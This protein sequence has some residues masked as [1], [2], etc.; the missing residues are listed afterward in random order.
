M[1]RALLALLV[2][3]VL[4]SLAHA[5]A[6][7]VQ[8]SCT[9]YYDPTG[10]L[11]FLI[12]FTVVNVSLPTSVCDLHFVPEPTPPQVGCEMVQCGGPM[13][14]SCFLNPSGGADWFANTPADCI[15]PGSGKGGFSFLLDPAYCCYVVQFTDPTGAVILEQEECFCSDPV[16]KANTTWG[17][18]KSRY[19]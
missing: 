1:S 6:S 11:F 2:L 5:D 4:P 18:L 7:I 14:W 10:K 17:L 15:P 13:G 8:D 3:M 12:D 9:G 19:R 16:P